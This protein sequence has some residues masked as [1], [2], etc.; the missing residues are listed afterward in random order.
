MHTGGQLKSTPTLK[1]FKTKTSLCLTEGRKRMKQ[2]PGKAEI[3]ITGI[4][5][6][7]EWDEDDNITAIELSTEDADYEVESNRLGKELFDYVG[8]EVEVVGIVSGGNNIDRI[9]ITSYEILDAY[10]EEDDDED[11]DYED[12][13][14]DDVFDDDEL[15]DFDDK[16][17]YR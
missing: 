12:Y 3:K 17:D 1:I 16:S 14:D 15:D 5:N 13:E 11:Y 7:L 2:K 4:I 9:R 6:S 10:D 8:E